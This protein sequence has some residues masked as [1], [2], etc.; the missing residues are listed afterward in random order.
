MEF[1]GFEKQDID[2][3]LKNEGIIAVTI[4]GVSMYPMLK[5]RRDCVV[6]RKYTGGAS[7]YDV[8]LYR[9]PRKRLVLHRLIK[10]EK[11][12]GCFVIRGDNCIAREYIPEDSVIGILS[13][14]TRKGKDL[15]V[16]NLGYKIYSRLIVFFHPAVLLKYRAK[17]V[18]SRIKRV[19]SGR[20]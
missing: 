17:G 5:N 3:V 8:L 11:T 18:L 10:N 15:T 1:G 13:E 9:D 16:D 4:S 19:I 7:K 2:D 14:F 6:I 12:N 20:K